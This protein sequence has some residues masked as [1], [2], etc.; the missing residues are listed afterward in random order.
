MSAL[1][2]FSDER[3]IRA[4]ARGR[5]AAFEELARR[6]GRGIKA[7]ALR[8]LRNPQEAEHVYVET[9]T[10]LA[11]AAKRWKSTGTP[12][13]F[14]YTIAHN[15]CIDT[16]RRRRTEREARPHLVD[17][18]QNRATQ[19]TPE[20]DAM[21]GELAEQLERAIATLSEEHRTVLLLRT[22]HGLSGK[23]TAAVVG[24]DEGQV[25]S[26]LSYARKKLREQLSAA[27]DDQ[28]NHARGK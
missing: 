14:A 15:L 5:Q 24:L 7:H 9:F 10:R 3:L 4:F 17:M 2:T 26:Q 18:E 13:A 27:R 12:K 1:D 20:S 28:P 16:L 23:E 25:R 11:V 21:L 22:V 6:H 8:L 19:R